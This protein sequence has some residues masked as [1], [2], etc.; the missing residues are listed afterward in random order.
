IHAEDYD[1]FDGSAD[2]VK[3]LFED[4]NFNTSWTNRH[5]NII[6][7]LFD[8]LLGRQQANNDP[9]ELDSQELDMFGIP[10]SPPRFK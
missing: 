8:G 10:I 7:G 3:A 1:N 4:N 9:E 2:I 5:Y 6:Y